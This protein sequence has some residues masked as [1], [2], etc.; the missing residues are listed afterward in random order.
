MVVICLEAK[1]EL[2]ATETAPVAFGWWW[3]WADSP[4]STA[5]LLTAMPCSWVWLAGT[6]RPSDAV[7]GSVCCCICK[8]GYE[9]AFTSGHTTPVADL[10]VVSPE[11]KDWSM[12]RGCIE[13]TPGSLSNNLKGKILFHRTNRTNFS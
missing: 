10:M 13:K 4:T 7:G 9:V 3:E 1:T 11:T 12:L 8:R 2:G 5:C 6:T